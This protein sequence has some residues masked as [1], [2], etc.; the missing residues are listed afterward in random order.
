MAVAGGKN[1]IDIRMLKLQPLRQFHTV[2]AHHFHIQEG[3]IHLVFLCKIQGILRIAE[4]MDP[5]IGGCRCNGLRQIFQSQALV[6]YCNYDHGFTFS[7]GI[8]TVTVVPSPGLLL[9]STVAF[10]LL[11]RRWRILIRPTCTLPSSIYRST[12]KPAP[13]SETVI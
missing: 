13:V 2:H 9:I 12:S 5:G 3:H 8:V 11:A 1:D 7:L 6:I 10:I 4:A